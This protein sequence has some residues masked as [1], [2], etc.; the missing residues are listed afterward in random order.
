M[1]CPAR[2][3]PSP[4][5]CD[6]K[7]IFM[8]TP[9]GLSLSRPEMENWAL[10]LLMWRSSFLF[11]ALGRCTKSNSTCDSSIRRPTS[12][13]FGAFFR[14]AVKHVRFFHIASLLAGSE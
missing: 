5:D 6:L 2:P 8:L 13:R 10:I 12:H 9:T 11:G 14:I 4:C 7:F 1:H 3:R